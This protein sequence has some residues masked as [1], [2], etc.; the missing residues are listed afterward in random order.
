MTPLTLQVQET[1]TAGV[2]E[3]QE[4]M[5]ILVRGILEMLLRAL[6]EALMMGGGHQ[7][8]RKCVR[9]GFVILSNVL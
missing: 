3:A 5:M 7:F 8:P 4:M 2:E 1:L 6:A 9:L